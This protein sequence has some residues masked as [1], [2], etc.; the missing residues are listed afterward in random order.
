MTCFLTLQTIF[1]KLYRKKKNVFIIIRVCWLVS[2]IR[3][4]FNYSASG[5]LTNRPIAVVLLA[6]IVTLQI[7]AFLP[8]IKSA[9]IE[10]P[11]VTR[12]LDPFIVLRGGKHILDHHSLLSASDYQPDLSHELDSRPPSSL[13][14]AI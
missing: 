6:I 8:L 1:F 5:E 13:T 12:R 11:Q 2:L 9:L 7:L 10:F 4:T 14:S 3:L